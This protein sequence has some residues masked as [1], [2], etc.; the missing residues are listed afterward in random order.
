[1]DIFGWLIKPGDKVEGAVKDDWLSSFYL[2][3]LGAGSATSGTEMEKAEG[4]ACGSR[5]HRW[6]L[7]MLKVR[8]LEDI[9]VETS[10]W[11]DVQNSHG[12]GLE[13]KSIQTLAL[14]SLI[15][16][17]SPLLGNSNNKRS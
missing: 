8:W 16:F 9:Q 1:M 12:S 11:L 6:V 4:G 17:P 14:S 10:R 2:G 7:N 3:S 5:I 13:N 15:I